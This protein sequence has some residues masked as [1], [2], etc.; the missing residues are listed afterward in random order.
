MF[1]KCICIGVSC[2]FLRGMCEHHEGKTSCRVPVPAV[3]SAV[4]PL[5][6][7][8]NQRLFVLLNTEEMTFLF[9]SARLLLVFWMYR[10]LTD[11]MWRYEQ[12]F[13]WLLSG[14]NKEIF[15]IAKNNNS[16]NLPATIII[17]SRCN[18]INVFNYINYFKAF[19]FRKSTSWNCMR[20]YQRCANINQ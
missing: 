18:I 17:A 8:Y 20:R 11:L 3:L 10:V 7:L 1:Q 16:K 9:A 12:E 5:T 19:D 4:K 2:L 6:P 14:L 13:N 15:K